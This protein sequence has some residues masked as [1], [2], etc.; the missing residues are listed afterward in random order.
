MTTEAVPIRL[1]LM[2]GWVGQKEV[3]GSKANPVIAGMETSW[4]SLVGWPSIVSDE[5]ANCAAAQGAALVLE[6]FAALGYTLADFESEDPEI[7]AEA[8]EALEEAKR[9]TPLPPRDNRL[10]ARSYATWGVDARKDPRPGD[11]IIVPRPP[12]AYQGHIMIIDEVQSSLRRYNCIGAN[13]S[14]MTSV[15][16]VGFDADIVA[17]RRPVAATVKDLLAAGSNGVARGV[18]LKRVGE[19]LSVGTPAAAGAAKVAGKIAE[20]A[21]PQIPDVST[22][23]GMKTATEQIGVV[24][25]FTDAL[26]AFGSLFA[27]YPWLLAPIAAGIII[28]MY[29]VE[30]IAARIRSYV[31]GVPLSNQT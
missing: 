28:R 25:A 29:G 13:Q 4:F 3:P 11:L 14:D 19:A 23:D 18:A 30:T 24:Q 15:T 31:S 22:I 16:H 21:A 10:L 6:T 7:V 17:I 1:A 27:R 9:S 20:E 5:V 12:V 8:R 2:R 26:I